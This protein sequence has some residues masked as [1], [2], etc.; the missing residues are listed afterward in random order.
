MVKR[1]MNK[2]ISKIV[3]VPNLA[4]ISNLDQ[5]KLLDLLEKRSIFPS[6][7]KEG[8][9]YYEVE[10]LLPLINSGELN[11]YHDSEK[12]LGVLN[13]LAIKNL[14]ILL[15][16]KSEIIGVAQITNQSCIAFFIEEYSGCIY[17]VMRQVL[18]S[19]TDKEPTFTRKGL[20]ATREEWIRIVKVLR[21]IEARDLLETEFIELLKLPRDDGKNAIQVYYHNF[22]SVTRIVIGKL[23][24]YKSYSGKCGGASFD[25]SEI[26]KVTNHL[27]KMINILTTVNSEKAI[28]NIE[29]ATGVL[30]VGD[31]YSN[32]L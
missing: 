22:R 3:S 20:N 31:D 12:S 19:S 29:K 1:N 8:V 27:D 15:S 25:M 4:V 30:E 17:G 18:F 6:H 23:Y 26:E 10:H 32:L 9:R 16:S 28:H 11:I 7:I 13:D 2:S 21:D 14:Q 5:F 24:N